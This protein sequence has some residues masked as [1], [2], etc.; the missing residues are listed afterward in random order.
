MQRIRQLRRP[1]TQVGGAAL[2]SDGYS[3][4]KQ[5][6]N[7]R[8]Y[9]LVVLIPVVVTLW[10]FFRNHGDLAS[11]VTPVG[12]PTIRGTPPASMREVIET[13]RPTSGINIVRSPSPAATVVSDAPPPPPPPPPLRRAAKS[14]PP[15]EPPPPAP[16]PPPSKPPVR[17]QMRLSPRRERSSNLFARSACLRRTSDGDAA[18]QNASD[19]HHEQLRH[20]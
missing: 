6:R 4:Q 20:G 10:N 18:S 19:S 17:S 16:I 5:P 8:V 9:Y 14:P 3:G 13:Q 15:A 11:T 7:K 12:S 2:A 1:S